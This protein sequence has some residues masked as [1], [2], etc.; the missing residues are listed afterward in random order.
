VVPPSNSVA[1]LYFDN[2]T[3]DT[4]DAYITDGLTEEI[5]TALVRSGRLQLKSPSAV[6][7]AQRA[8]GASLRELARALAV[9]YLVEGSVRRQGTR[10]RIIVRLVGGEAENTIWTQPFTAT[11]AD[12]L[13][14]EETI[15]RAVVDGVTGQMP[16]DGGS[17]LIR[18]PTVSSAAHDHL[19]RGNY[20]LARRSERAVALAIDE[21]ESAVRADPGYV[22]ALARVAYAYGIALDWGWRYRGLPADSLLARG[23][24]AVD[25][26]I[27]QDSTNSD[28]WLA[29]AHLLRYQ[30]PRTFAG[31]LEAATRAIDLDPRNAEAYHRYGEVL[32]R[33]GRDAEAVAA[34]DSALALEPERPVTLATLLEIA[35]VEH[36]VRDA[37]RWAD[38][39]LAID[40]TFPAYQYRAFL[41][42]RLGDVRGARADAETALRLGGGLPESDAAMA[43]VEV[44]EGDSSAA[45]V[46]LDRLVALARD[47]MPRGDAPLLLAAAL[48]GAGRSPQALE[49]LELWAERIRGPRLWVYLYLPEFAPLRG[50]PR[51]ERLLA[52][53]RPPGARDP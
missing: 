25:R 4:A 45:R 53:S 28:A 27:H 50:T 44:A 41:R 40:P 39:A 20:Q 17:R 2:L 33:F 3:R 14:V 30:N 11:T 22:A 38:S 1:V 37:A 13:T 16:S 8:N 24:S 26:A 18:R 6:R 12:L 49:V 34:L 19:L 42:L 35:W 10:L 21:Y 29:R 15:A 51:F 36:R 43:A 47:S 5:H 23:V 7:R 52:E 46:R 31:V 32:R 48:V 9:R